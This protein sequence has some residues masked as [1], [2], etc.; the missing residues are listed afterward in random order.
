MNRRQKIILTIVFGGLVLLFLIN[1]LVLPNKSYFP[2]KNLPDVQILKV[3]STSADAAGDVYTHCI[4][5]NNTNN[6]LSVI[7]LKSIFYEK[8]EI[9]ATG[10]GTGE[11]IPA[12]STKVV[13]CITMSVPTADSFYVQIDNVFWNR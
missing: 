4:V 8:G 10:A 2:K 6:L 1:I 3:N 11:N 7:S 9:V 5:K 12:N 13:D